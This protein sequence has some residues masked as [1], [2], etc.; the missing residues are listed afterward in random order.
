MKIST[1]QK[2]LCIRR[3]YT[4]I[5]VYIIYVYI[6]IIGKCMYVRSITLYYV[7]YKV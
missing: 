1:Q 6:I 7:P 2:F 3:N 5:Y 4:Y